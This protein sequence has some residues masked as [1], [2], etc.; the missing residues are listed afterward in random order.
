VHLRKQ[1][2]YDVTT[3]I[4]KEPYFLTA[5]PG[6]G[7]NIFTQYVKICALR[8]LSYVGGHSLVIS[9]LSTKYNIPPAGIKR[10]ERRHLVQKLNAGL[11]QG[12]RLILVCAPAGYGKTTLVGEWVNQN[13]PN[14]LANPSDL[15]AVETSIRV[16]WLTC[17]QE[18][19]DLARFLSYLIAALRQVNPPMGEGLLATFHA[20]KPPTPQTL[21]TLLIN[22]L[23]EIPDHLV[24]VLDDFHTITSQ[25]IH[26]FLTFLIEHQPP[27]MCLVLITRA[28]PAL[29][30]ARLRG[31]G[32]LDEIRQNE[33]SFTPEESA[34][35]LNRTMGVALSQ[36][37]LSTLERRTEGWAAGLQ[38]A[39]LS[40]RAA[41][42]VPAFIEAFSGGH[43]YIADYLTDEVLAQQSGSINSFL[44]QTSILERL[45]APLCAA[46]TGDTNAQDILETLRENNLF[47]V[48]LD[49]QKTWYR[50]HT[51]F[52][53]LLQNRLHQSQGN[54][55]DELH[56][57]A[58]RWY[59]ENGFLMPAIEHA[60]SGHDVEQAAALLEQ[61][62]ES[63]FI[64]GQL[65]TLLRWLESLPVETKNRRSILWIFHGLT[66]IWCGKSSAPVKP[67]LPGLD[68]IFNADG[69]IGEAHT[70]R[71]LYA[72][73]EGYALEA[74]QLAQNVLQEL[75]PERTLFR[76]L[77]ADTLGMAKILQCE[78]AAAIRAFE[79]LA[80]TASRAGYGMFEIMALSHLA[81]L[82]VQQGQLHAAATGYQRALELA[83]HKMGKCSPVTGNV[84]LGLGELA[85]EWNDL[86]GALGYFL[87]SVEMFAQFSDIGIP[88]AYL[89]I[90][91]V[92]AAQGDWK[93]GQ[94]YLE[95]ARQYAQ[96]SKATRLNDRLVDG[97]QARFWITRGELWLAEQWAQENGLIEHP[98]TEII[99]T[100]GQNVA[101]SE[102]IQNDYLTLA[103]LYLAQNKADAAL[104]V[105]DPLLNVANSMGHMRRVIH[106]LVLK[107]LALQHKKEVGL[108][109]DVLGQTL[110]LAEPEEYLQVFLDEGEPMA[111][112]LYQTIARGVSPVYAKKMLTAFSQ[113]SSYVVV[114][115]EKKAPVE[116]LLE[117][118]SEREH[119]VLA[120]IAAGLSNREIS[121]R[122]HITLSTVKGH[123]A[124]IYGKLG[125]NSRTQAISEA[126]RLGILNR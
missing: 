69:L 49:H 85:R 45:S 76:C 31:R 65:I 46:V 59:Q 35:F 25:P 78:T 16:A 87:E 21:A 88:I 99:E 123:T 5:Q 44:L 1:R 77:A 56:L 43:E 113:K 61:S 73:T 37:Q 117:P 54:Q 12:K 114:P 86:N 28:D 34:E 14:S 24:L 100:S 23:A 109:V 72:T 29:P 6:H 55:V 67:F 95:K 48:P 8:S 97:L 3:E 110:A 26:E 126:A 121:M 30:L 62:V 79:Q 58:S 125:V 66:L 96:A 38:L 119:E 39:A 20:S 107:A 33:L 94:E 64:S 47:L 27:R 36:E 41:Q 17:D 57:R 2:R 40:M 92:K 91:R 11:R 71:A 83:T 52:T 116:N 60:L 63:I 120:L 84:L 124:N 101:G 13:T 32:Q 90:A 103:R 15:K 50:Y 42:D 22:D 80:E 51:L 7:Y 106:I 102:F 10:V 108:A 53:D 118:I 112:L 4:P 104:Q 89:S 111:R 115:G 98:I 9:L 19:D 74:A 122:L 18:D 82:R 75:S 105:I 81:G 70:L 68:S 93:S